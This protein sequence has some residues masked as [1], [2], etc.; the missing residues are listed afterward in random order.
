MDH[1]DVECVKPICYIF[2]LSVNKNISH[3][4]ANDLCWYILVCLK[5]L[6]WWDESHLYILEPRTK[7]VETKVENPVNSRNDSIFQIPNSFL[8]PL[9]SMLNLGKFC[10]QKPKTLPITL[11][12][13][14]RELFSLKNWFLFCLKILSKIVGYWYFLKKSSLIAQW[15]WNTCWCI[16]CLKFNQFQVIKVICMNQCS[17]SA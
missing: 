16:L 17:Y 13:C 11:I 8:Y 4:F 14:E 9:I 10:C 1:V 3:N 12:S 7:F 2:C 15:V 6:Y 5:T